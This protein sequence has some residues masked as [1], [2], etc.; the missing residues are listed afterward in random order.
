MTVSSTEPKIGPSG[1]GALAIDELGLEARIGEILNRHPAVGLA[2][3]V[4]GNGRFEFFSGHGLSDIAS[5]TP[6]TEDTVFRIGSVTKTFTAIAV[7][8]LWEQGLVDLDAPANDY[9]GPTG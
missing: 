1:H 6:V 7:L 3:G 8:Q 2:V 4:I 9:C 5:N